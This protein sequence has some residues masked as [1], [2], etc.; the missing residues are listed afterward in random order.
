MNLRPNWVALWEDQFVRIRDQ[1][2]QERGAGM[3]P[4][5][6]MRNYSD[7]AIDLYSR[8]EADRRAQ[9]AVIRHNEAIERKAAKGLL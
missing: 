2:F 1:L 8:R 6:G 9:E 4:R 7:S 5:R 3:R